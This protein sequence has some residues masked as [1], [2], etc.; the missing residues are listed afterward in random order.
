MYNKQTVN[1]FFFFNIFAHLCHLNTYKG[2]FALFFNNLKIAQ[3]KKKLVKTLKK[4]NV[5]IDDKETN[6][7]E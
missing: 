7:T 2:L 5:M 3:I 4:E 1:E 6:K